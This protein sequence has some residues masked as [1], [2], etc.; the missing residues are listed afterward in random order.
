MTV[1][2]VGQDSES[3]LTFVPHC[4]QSNVLF[5]AVGEPRGDVRVETGDDLLEEFRLTRGLFLSIIYDLNN[6]LFVFTP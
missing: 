1:P 2:H 3:N 4:I 6:T 5:L